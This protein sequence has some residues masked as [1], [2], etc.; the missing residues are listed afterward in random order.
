MSSQTGREIKKPGGD[1]TPPVI[2]KVGGGGP[3]SNDLVTIKSEDLAFVETVH[4]PPWKSASTDRVKL[5]SLDI[6]DGSDQHHYDFPRGQRVSINMKYG[7]AQLELTE[8]DDLVS[9]DSVLVFTSDQVT[10]EVDKKEGRWNQ[11]TATFSERITQV[12]LNVGNREE[13]HR[14]STAN[15]ELKIYYSRALPE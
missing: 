4:E 10:F 5:T 11:A 1:P 2:V 3:G 9:N 6:D 13:L 15:P 12:V 8:A 14:F 7:S